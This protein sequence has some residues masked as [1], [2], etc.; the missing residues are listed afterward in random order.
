MRMMEND[1]DSVS[2]LTWMLFAHSTLAAR[3]FISVKADER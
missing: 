2:E 3:V 1:G